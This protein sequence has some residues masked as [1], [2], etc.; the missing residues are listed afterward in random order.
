MLFGYEAGAMMVSKPAPAKRLLFFLGAHLDN[1]P[2]L[3]A[4]GIKLLRAAIAWSIN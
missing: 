1:A 4:D 3:S 2:A